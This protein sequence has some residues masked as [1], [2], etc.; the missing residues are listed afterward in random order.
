MTQYIYR[1]A[2]TGRIVTEKWAKKHPATTV[3]EKVINMGEQ[4]EG[5]KRIAKS[6]IG[7]SKLIVAEISV[8]RSIKK[9]LPVREKVCIAG[10]VKRNKKLL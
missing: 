3:R 6:M 2:K 10:F 5:Y 9:K 1:S 7:E 8:K 4:I